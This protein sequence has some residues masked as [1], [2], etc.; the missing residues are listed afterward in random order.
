MPWPTHQRLLERSGYEG[1]SLATLFA[2]NWMR[3]V[4]QPPCCR[5]QQPLQIGCKQIIALNSHYILVG[6]LTSRETLYRWLAFEA[7]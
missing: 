7:S 5:K 4:D 6:N 1:R 2:N 3:V